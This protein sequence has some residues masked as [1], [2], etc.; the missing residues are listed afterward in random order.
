MNKY[1]R[2]IAKFVEDINAKY[3]YALNCPQL[4]ISE[5]KHWAKT[6]QV[7]VNTCNQPGQQQPSWFSQA[8]CCNK[9]IKVYVM[10]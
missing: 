6:F 2:E 3:G 5:I 1:S 8:T 7:V 4:E 10:V 9:C